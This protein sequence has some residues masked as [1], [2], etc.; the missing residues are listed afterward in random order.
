MDTEFRPVTGVFDD[1]AVF[2]PYRVSIMFTE[3]IV[4]G[5]PQKPE[6]IESW[7]RDKFLGGD[8]ELAIML[9]RTL[10]DLEIEVP[11]DAGVE[12]MIAAAKQMA[13]ERN[14]N[15]FRRLANGG[16]LG[17]GAYQL[18]A[19][20]K[21]ATAILY[22]YSAPD[23]KG[24]WGVTRKAARSFLAE[25]VHVDDYLIPLGRHEPD[26]TFMQVGHVDGPRGPRSTLTYYDYCVQ[27]EL[28]F[29]VSSSEDAVTPEQWRRIL[30]QG[31]RDGLGALRSLGH[32]RFKVTAFDRVD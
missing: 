16:G 25:R 31:Q 1:A 28:T 10:A 20:L 32:G 13:A 14:G 6:I 11:E 21:E 12:D 7:L 22:P 29:T 24:K 18:K 30:V 23:G 4:G 17:L 15:T 19:M 27:P 5:V 8:Q 3:L 2:T 9:R 26:G